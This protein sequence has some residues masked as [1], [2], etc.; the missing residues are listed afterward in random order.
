MNEYDDIMS[1]TR[2]YNVIKYYL[3]IFLK[4]YKTV[5]LVAALDRTKADVN[6]VSNI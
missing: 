2:T 4:I 6:T 1:G 3:E 5:C